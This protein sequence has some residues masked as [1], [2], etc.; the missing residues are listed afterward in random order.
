MVVVEQQETSML[1]TAQKSVPVLFEL[2]LMLATIL[3]VFIPTESLRNQ[4]EA[5]VV[6]AGMLFKQILLLETV[7]QSLQVSP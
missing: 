3:L 1:L 2:I 5:V 4:L 6:Q 7:L